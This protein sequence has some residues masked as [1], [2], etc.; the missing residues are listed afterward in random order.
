LAG[1]LYARRGHDSAVQA[2]GRAA[3]ATMPY[4]LLMLVAVVALT[5]FPQI[6]LFLPDLVF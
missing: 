4:W 6:A 1:P 3:L 2:L 5:L